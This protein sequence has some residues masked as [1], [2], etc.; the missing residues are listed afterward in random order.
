MNTL[1]ENIVLIWLLPVLFEIVLPLVMLLFYLLG[2][3]LS[4]TLGG[5]ARLAGQLPG[6]SGQ[7]T[8][9]R[10]EAC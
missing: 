6:G 1:R 2:R 4:G 8:E 3:I 7:A 9:I 5:E 10:T